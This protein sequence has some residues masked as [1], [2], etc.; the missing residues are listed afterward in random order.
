M[1]A[2]MLERRAE[3]DLDCAEDGLAISI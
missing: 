3:V 2:E 1:S